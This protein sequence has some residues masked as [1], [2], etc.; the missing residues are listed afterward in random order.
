MRNQSG[1]PSRYATRR[2]GKRSN[3]LLNT[4]SAKAIASDIGWPIALGMAN[5]IGAGRNVHRLHTQVPMAAPVNHYRTAQSSR[6]RVYRPVGFGAE[7]EVHSRSGEK[8]S[9][10]AELCISMSQLL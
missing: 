9:T 3:R 8:D 10:Y 4:I 7:V 1:P 5:S 6:F 2:P